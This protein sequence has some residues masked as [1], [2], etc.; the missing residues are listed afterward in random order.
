MARCLNEISRRGVLLSWCSA[1]SMA[2]V[3]SARGE[4]SQD[5][6]SKTELMEPLELA[7]ELKSHGAVPHVYCVAFP[8]LYRGKHILGAVFAGPPA[9][10]RVSPTCAQ[11]SALY[12]KTLRSSFTAVVAR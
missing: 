4:D 7:T 9:K 12:R 6:W 2:L 1:T 10:P 3:P 5:P 11:Q 8:V